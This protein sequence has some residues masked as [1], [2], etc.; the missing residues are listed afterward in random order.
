[1][2][3]CEELTILIQHHVQQ[4]YAIQVYMGRV[5]I[6]VSEIL[7]VLVEGSLMNGMLNFS[8]KEAA[9]KFISE[10]NVKILNMC[11]IPEDGKLK[12]LSFSTSDKERVI[13]ILEYGERVD[14]SSLF[15]FIEPG[16]SD[17]YVNP[18]IDRAFMNP[19]AMLPTLN[20]LSD[21]K[22]EDGKPL[23]IAPQNVLARAVKKLQSSNGVTLKALAELEFYVIATHQVGT[24]F[25]GEPDKNYHESSP[26]ALFEDVR[27][28]ILGTLSIVGIP[29]KYGHCEVGRIITDS[30]T[31]MEQHEIEFMPQNLSEMAETV[32][33]AK[34][35]VRN[36]CSRHGL[37]ASFIPKIDLN[38]AGNGMHIHLCGFKRGR[39]VISKP[40]GNLSH[41]AL[42]MIGGI[43]KFAPSLAA[44]G[45]PTPVSY[46]RFIACKETPMHICWSVR[47]RL[48]LIRIPLWWTFKK[49]IGKTEG[50]RKTFEY[51][52]PDAF[53]NTHLLLAGL[54]LAANCGLDNA[55]E[56]LKLAGNLHAKAVKEEEGRFKTLPRSCHEAADNLLKD[57]K[58]YEA[59]EIFPPKLI[60]SIIRKLNDF[61]DGDLWNKLSSKPEETQKM[62]MHYLH[63]G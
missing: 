33:V 63:Y 24:L 30:G 20:I 11:H 21:Y 27:N 8:G 58:I 48:A 6:S 39:D 40:D 14:G 7:K 34:W 31:I 38:H 15:S 22:D 45:N 41:E 62:L 47:N 1:M 5:K 51:R 57:R 44:F 4:L 35:V 50:C 32:S 29:T 2:Y 9:L 18:R 49:G 60:E 23:D 42:S 13:E 53:A 43:L 28:E 16:K 52:A 54:A 56:S 17:I 19:F 46:L 36:V 3:R 26:F 55:G 61:D 12:T 10:N 59:D 37:S 25:P